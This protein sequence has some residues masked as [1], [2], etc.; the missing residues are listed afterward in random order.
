MEFDAKPS[1]MYK[2]KG[3]RLQCGTKQNLLI[4]QLI[5]CNGKEKEEE[6]EQKSVSKATRLTMINNGTQ[7]GFNIFVRD[8]K[9]LQA[10]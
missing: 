1:Y 5:P 3:C 9:T 2:K 6:E 8:G 10:K 4:E 7:Y